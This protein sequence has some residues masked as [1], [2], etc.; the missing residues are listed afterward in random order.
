M[1]KSQKHR[2][3]EDRRERLEPNVEW[4]YVPRLTPGEYPAYCRTAKIYRDSVFKRWVCAIQFDVLND[5]QETIGRLTWFINLGSGEKP[6][7]NRRGNYFVAWQ[8]ANGE[9]PRRQDRM[10]PRVFTRRYATVVVADTVRDSR[11]ELTEKE[12]AYSVVRSV[13]HWDTS[14][15]PQRGAVS[16]TRRLLKKSGEIDQ[17]LES[18]PEEMKSTGRSARKTS[19]ELG[20]GRGQG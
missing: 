17:N 10:S 15:P 14:G 19:R 3:D 5:S 12:L 1:A 7:A 6:K 16:L 2:K 18:K 11:T 9:P 20:P 8:D 13:V 4:R